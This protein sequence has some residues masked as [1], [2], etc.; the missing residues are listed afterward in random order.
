[1]HQEPTEPP[2]VSIWSPEIIAPLRT[3][4]QRQGVSAS[5]VPSA[6]TLS[7]VN[8]LALQRIG[9]EAL[10]TALLLSGVV[11]SG[12]MGAALSEGNEAI[13]LLGNTIS[14]GA[15]LVCL[16]L[17]FGP[18]SGAHFNPAVTLVFLLRREVSFKMA[19]AYLIA[20]IVG[21]L[22]GVFAA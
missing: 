9:A 6:K 11:G 21:G 4:W 2:T 7:F 5:S 17:I 3:I 22:L 1:M 13:A 12:I 16:I 18:V 14:T 19:L 10:G 20:Q 8:T 15:L